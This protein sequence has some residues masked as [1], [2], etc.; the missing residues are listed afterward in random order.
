MVK[1]RVVLTLIS[2]ALWGWLVYPF[3]A[4]A[5]GSAPW[6]AIPLFW[7][8]VGPLR[9]AVWVVTAGWIESGWNAD[10]VGDGGT[11]IGVLQFNDG[12]RVQPGDR[13]SV[14]DSA[15][16]A[17][18]YT[19]AVGSSDTKSYLLR[20][21][22]FR[23]PLVGFMSWRVWW[24]YGAEPARL[25]N[26]NSGRTIGE[27]WTAGLSERQAEREQRGMLVGSLVLTLA[28]LGLWGAWRMVGGARV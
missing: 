20:F 6:W 21:L 24:R 4:V 16:A 9:W 7:A 8:S 3:V 5:A 13:R 10:A 25:A 11:S 12:A 17:V 28:V 26:D 1:T 14:W 18:P 19:M 15:T 22:G 23:I 2:G 27:L